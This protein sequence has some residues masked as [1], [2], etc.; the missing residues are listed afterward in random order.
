MKKL[1]L[2][3]LLAVGLAGFGRAGWA[4]EQKIAT[5]DVQK[6]YDSYY[7]SIQSRVA[8]QQELA[9]A[10]KEESQ[11]MDSAR[12]HDDEY[13]QLVDK[14]NDQA[15]SAE[16]R[17]KSKKAADDKRAELEVDKQSINEFDQ[18]AS[19]HLRAKT[20]QRMLEIFKEIN[21]VVKAH[22][23]AA[24]YSM[25]LD[26][27]SEGAN[28]V[29]VVLYANGKD[30]LTDS[31][32]KELNAAAPPGSLDTNALTAPISTNLTIPSNPSK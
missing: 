17:D 21:G 9:E 25:V 14:A 28:H 18:R 20:E 19:L 24:G 3:G 8:I 30:D 31:V 4:A 13:R 6:A 32:I 10:K 22:A 5:F 11:M 2:I 27:S 12:R 1:M 7:K 15:V 23:Q 29:P 16:Q 26:S